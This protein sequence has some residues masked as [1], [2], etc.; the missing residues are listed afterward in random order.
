MRNYCRA[1]HTS[2]DYLSGMP[3]CRVLDEMQD[4]FEDLAEERREQ[5]RRA[6]QERA[7]AKAKGRVRHARRR[8]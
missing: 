2:I 7:R 5:E 1:F 8:R 3:F 6:E 4:A